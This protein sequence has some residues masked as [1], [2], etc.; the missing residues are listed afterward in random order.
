MSGEGA[1]TPRS[2]GGKLVSGKKGPIPAALGFATPVLYCGATGCSTLEVGLDS[3]SWVRRRSRETGPLSLG[4]GVSISLSS[5]G[6]RELSKLWSLWGFQGAG[7]AAALDEAWLI[8]L[9]VL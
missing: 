4:P 2:S 9:S 6:G 3:L 1:S 8:P 7:S 5:P